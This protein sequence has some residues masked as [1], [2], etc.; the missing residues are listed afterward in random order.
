[1]NKITLVEEFVEIECPK[2]V[3]ITGLVIYHR[4]DKI[5]M[6]LN[7]YVQCLKEEKKLYL[8]TPT[9]LCSIV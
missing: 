6:F 7:D 9:Y 8:K 5:G 4:I 3:P 2:L 1:M